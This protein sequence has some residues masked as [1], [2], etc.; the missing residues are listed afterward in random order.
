MEFLGTK[1]EPAQNPNSILDKKRKG[2]PVHL[3]QVRDDQGRQR[4]HGAFQGGFSAGYF[5]TVGSKEG[6]FECSFQ[7]SL[8]LR[9]AAEAF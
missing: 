4:L 6:F 2:I 1:L 8:V 9:M 5:N 3:Q 7:Y